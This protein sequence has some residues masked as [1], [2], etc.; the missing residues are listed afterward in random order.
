MP[1]SKGNPT[2]PELREQIKE[3]VKSEQKGNSNVLKSFLTSLQAVVLVLGRLGK[4]LNLRRDTKLRAVTTR[5][6]LAPKIS[7]KKALQKKNNSLL[8]A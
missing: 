4:L 6:S 8:V 7:Q 3:E 5:M 1:S 2:D